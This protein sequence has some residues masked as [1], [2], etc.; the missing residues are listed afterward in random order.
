ML[1]VCLIDEH[2]TWFVILKLVD[3]VLLTGGHPS[4]QWHPQDAK[5]DL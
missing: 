1:V 5:M 2:N 3:I 4:K